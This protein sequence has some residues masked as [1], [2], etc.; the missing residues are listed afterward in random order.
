MINLQPNMIERAATMGIYWDTCWGCIWM[1]F[2]KLAGW[3][4]PELNGGCTVIFQQT[5][6]DSW[7][8][9]CNYHLVI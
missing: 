7:R 8:K 4:I 2:S 3:E 9:I 6:F 5:V 1:V